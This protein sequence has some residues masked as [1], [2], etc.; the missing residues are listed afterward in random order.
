MDPVKSS[1]GGGI[2]ATVTLTVILLLADF[3]LAGTNL[4]IFATFTSLC[5][6]GGQ[7]YCEVT[8]PM[9]AVL[10]FGWYLVLYA[11]AWPLFFG[12][13]TWGLPG[14]SG[15]VH[16]ALFGLV[17]WLGFGVF[18]L[19]AGRGSGTTLSESLP[20]LGVTLVAFLVY[21]LVLG[22]VYDR[23][24]EHRTFLTSGTT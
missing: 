21:G 8:S 13:L 10:T 19:Y 6:V 3:V 7:P 22:G 5:A 16:G 23:L 9:A 4:F 14:E 2:V 1:L 18:V 17:V 24:A 11:F 12:G 15:L 20:I